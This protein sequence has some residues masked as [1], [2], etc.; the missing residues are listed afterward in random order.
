M[1]AAKAAQSQEQYEAE[2]APPAPM[3]DGASGMDVD[4]AAAPAPSDAQ[5]ESSAAGLKRKADEE[6][7]EGEAK[8]AKPGAC[9][10]LWLHPRASP[11]LTIPCWHAQTLPLRPP[12]SSGKCRPAVLAR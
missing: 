4:A 12:L 3:A 7:A 9:A 11:G 1:Y 5:A 2:Q 6:L 10:S 8:K